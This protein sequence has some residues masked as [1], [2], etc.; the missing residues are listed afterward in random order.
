VGD[1]EA[2]TPVVVESL[3]KYHSDRIGPLTSNRLS[4]SGT[5][6]GG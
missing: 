6:P 3:L 5:V 2:A 4:G 1:C